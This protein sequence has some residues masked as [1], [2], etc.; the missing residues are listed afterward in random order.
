MQFAKAN[1][2]EKDVHQVVERL[3]AHRIEAE[4]KG[5]AAGDPI[6]SDG[7][8]VSSGKSLGVFSGLEKGSSRFFTGYVTA[9]AK[10]AVVLYLESITREA[11]THLELGNKIFLGLTLKSS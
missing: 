1:L 7:V 5:L 11:R 10:T 9:N 6:I 8:K 2:S 3:Y 4:R